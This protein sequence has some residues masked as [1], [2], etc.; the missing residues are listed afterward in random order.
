MAIKFKDLPKR[1]TIVRLIW[2]D[3]GMYNTGGV[4]PS[5]MSIGK[6]EFF[7]RVVRRSQKHQELTI[8]MRKPPQARKLDKYNDFYFTAK[9]EN[10][11]KLYI[12][13]AVEEIG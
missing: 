10:I 6:D 13:E 4:H 11:L 9:V 8:A 3:S 1:G 12:L 5:Q 2:Q 7:G